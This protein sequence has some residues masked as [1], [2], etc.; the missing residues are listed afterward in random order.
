MSK[1][2]VSTTT[3]LS[4]LLHRAHPPVVVGMRNSG[5]NA[6]FLEG[7]IEGWKQA[8]LQLAKSTE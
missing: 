5:F 3:E 4:K 2:S 1:T 7:G 8:G 6:C